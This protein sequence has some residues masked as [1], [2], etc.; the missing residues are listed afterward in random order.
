MEAGTRVRYIHIDSE[1]DKATGYYP[2]VGTLGTIMKTRGNDIRV[3]WD[4]GTKNG[5]WWCHYTDVE[6]VEVSVSNNF[7]E[8]FWE[9]VNEEYDYKDMLTFEEIQKIFDGIKM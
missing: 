1:E 3:K 9:V 8:K 7:I 5:A 4:S 2:P 6:E